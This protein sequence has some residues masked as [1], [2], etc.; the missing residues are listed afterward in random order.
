MSDGEGVR[1]GRENRKHPSRLVVFLD[2]SYHHGPDAQGTDSNG[3]H[4][5]ISL[6]VVAAQF[7][8]ALDADAGESAF[9]AQGSPDVRSAGAAARAA[10]NLVGL[11][12]TDGNGGARSIGECLCPLDNY[13]QF[14]SH[15]SPWSL[16]AGIRRLR[17]H[18]PPLNKRSDLWVPECYFKT[19]AG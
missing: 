9:H 14:V 3:V 8:A 4:T 5:R 11:A 17:C 19:H 16:L 1:R 6:S 2:G 18:G 12:F 10:D 15:G 13:C 7:L